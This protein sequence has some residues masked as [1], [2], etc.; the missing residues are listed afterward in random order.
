MSLQYILVRV[1]PFIIEYLLYPL[2]LEQ[3]KQVLLFYFHR[4]IQI[5]SF[6]IILLHLFPFPLPHPTGTFAQTEPV[7]PS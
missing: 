4:G 6:R 7:L 3:F 2:F 1:T 5:I